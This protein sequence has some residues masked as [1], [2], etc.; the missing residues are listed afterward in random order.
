MIKLK[1]F[2]GYILVILG[3]FSH[4][5]SIATGLNSSVVDIISLGVLL[6]GCGIIFAQDLKLY[7][8]VKSSAVFLDIFWLVICIFIPRINLSKLWPS[9]LMVIVAISF[10]IKIISMKLTDEKFKK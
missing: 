7:K 3:A 6:V 1:D 8:A 5:M 2:I 4:Y 9:M 10:A